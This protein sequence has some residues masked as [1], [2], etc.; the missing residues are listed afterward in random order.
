MFEKVDSYITMDDGR[1]PILFPRSI[2]LPYHM[3]LDDEGEIIEGDFHF[4]VAI[5][6]ETPE[7]RAIIPQVTARIQL[8]KPHPDERKMTLVDRHLINLDLVAARALY[9]WLTS[10]M[11]ELEDMTMAFFEHETQSR[12]PSDEP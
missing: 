12:G 11:R 10:Y 6:Y 7:G 9:T 3:E 1:W 5:M 8:E 2:S 4:S